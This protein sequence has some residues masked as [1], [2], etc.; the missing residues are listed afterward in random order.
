MGIAFSDTNKTCWLLSQPSL[1]IF[2]F[3]GTEKNLPRKKSCHNFSCCISPPGTE[4]HVWT[5]GG[6]TDRAIWMQTTDGFWLCTE[7]NIS[8]HMLSGNRQLLDLHCIL[9][10]RIWNRNKLHILASLNIPGIFLQEKVV[11][12]YQHSSSWH[13]HWIHDIC[14]D[15]SS[16][17]ECF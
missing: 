13:C 14:S 17:F 3:L 12:S 15:G 1:Y 16:Y 9:W 2:N 4:I 10:I 11:F 5:F 7:C 8:H 6:H